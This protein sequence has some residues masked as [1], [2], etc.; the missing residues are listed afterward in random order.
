MK[1]LMTFALGFFIARQVYINFDKQEARNK[2]AR[3]KRKVED[4]LEDIGLSKKEAQE[5][6]TEILKTQ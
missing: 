1:S 2:E 6:S 5:H 4:L 3:L